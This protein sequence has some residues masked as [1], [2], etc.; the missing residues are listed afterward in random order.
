MKKPETKNKNT[1]VICWFLTIG[2]MGII[3]YLSSLKGT[4]LPSLP[5]YFDKVVH[6][7]IYIPLAFLCSFSFRKSG[8]K[9]NVFLLSFIIAVFYGI[10]DEIH[11]LYVPGREFAAGDILA[12]SIGA[13]LGSYL[14]FVTSLKREIYSR[15]L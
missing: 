12:D 14:A 8:V 6:I 7:C 4:D 15:F 2:Y 9:K 11:Q 10:T 3:F 5:Q 1:A 13:L